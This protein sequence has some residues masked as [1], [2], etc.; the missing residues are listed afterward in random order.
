[1]RLPDGETEG[2][3]DNRR[4]WINLPDVLPSIVYSIANASQSL[5][6]SSGFALEGVTDTQL[7]SAR[8][9]NERLG[10]EEYIVPGMYTLA[11]ALHNA[12]QFALERGDTLMLYEVY[13]PRVTQRAVVD[14]MNHLMR[15]NPVA[16]SAITDSPW[17]LTWFVS[18]GTSNHQRAA[19]VDASLARVREM[20]TAQAGDY[21]YI[22][23]TEYTPVDTGTRI[24]E[25]SPAS[26]ITHA[27]MSITSRMVL[28]GN[29]NMTGAAITAGIV[30]MQY[31]FA[32]AGFD[33]LAS[34]WWHFDH[35]PS[36][37]VAESNGIVGDFFTPSVYSEPPLSP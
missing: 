26:A 12:Q 28:G 3:V 23:V 1:V 11:R 15:T 2:W 33:L 6:R 30:R 20:E 7:Y 37:A 4:C 17:T 27:P 8:S 16:N 10:R 35:Q 19:A 22:R 25:L 18:T 31:Y 14:A 32:I 9:F 34:E 24:H 29:V 21:S 5:F 36:R 13:R